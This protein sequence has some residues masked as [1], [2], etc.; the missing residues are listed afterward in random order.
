MMALYSVIRKS[1]YAAYRKTNKTGDHGVQWNKPV[2][3]RQTSFLSYAEFRLTYEYIYVCIYRGIK[4]E[5]RMYGK[6]GVKGEENERLMGGQE[7]QNIALL[8]SC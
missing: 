5:G 7:R 4:A 8:P 6:R 1:N 3:A 2:S